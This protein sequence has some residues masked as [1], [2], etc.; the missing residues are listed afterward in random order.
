MPRFRNEGWLSGAE[1]S[2]RLRINQSLMER[3]AERTGVRRL[4]RP[5]LPPLYHEADV[6]ALVSQQRV[7]GEGIRV[8]EAANS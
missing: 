4:I 5:K 8:P 1:A 6:A 2:R 7:E 3:F